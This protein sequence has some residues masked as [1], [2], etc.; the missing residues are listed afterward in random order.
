MKTYLP[1]GRTLKEKGKKLFTRKFERE[2]L[3]IW[4]HRRQN[5]EHELQLL[6]YDSYIIHKRLPSKFLQQVF[7]GSKK[8]FKAGEMNLV[9]NVKSVAN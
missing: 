7:N 1:Y 4:L 8:A 9:E 6:G 3:P 5:V 2:N